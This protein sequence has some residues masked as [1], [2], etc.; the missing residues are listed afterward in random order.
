MN[1]NKLK[2][3]KNIKKVISKKKIIKPIKNKKVTKIH[4]I[5][6]IINKTKKIK[7]F[8]KNKKKIILPKNVATAINKKIS[9]PEIDA[10][11]ANIFKKKIKLNANS[12]SSIRIGVILKMFEGYKLEE[13]QIASI[14]DTLEVNNVNVIGNSKENDNAFSDALTMI[15]KKT[16]NKN[17][18][19]N[20]V[21]MNMFANTISFSKPLTEEEEKKYV[22]LM[23]SKDKEI[24]EKARNILIYSN[25]RLVVSIAKRYMNKGVDLQDLILRGYLGLI[26]TIDKFEASENTKLGTY[27]TW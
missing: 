16:N 14:I 12:K 5:P 7:V 21:L 13:E 9:K 8:T 24:S 3:K 20:E 6:K 1:K 25:L 2:I 18:K 23:K 11:V 17:L 22:K 15:I 27:A 10:I 19:V 26:K 4:K